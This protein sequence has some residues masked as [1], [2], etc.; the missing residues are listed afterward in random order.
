MPRI[1]KDASG[2]KK[3]SSLKAPEV[4]HVIKANKQALK[5]PITKR[6]YYSSC[7]G[8]GCSHYNFDVTGPEAEL[9]D[10]KPGKMSRNNI[11]ALRQRDGVS[12]KQ[13]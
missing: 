4:S 6:L 7:C 5:K 11:L 2:K 13:V 1:Q 3:K 8:C 10:V 9:K 12:V